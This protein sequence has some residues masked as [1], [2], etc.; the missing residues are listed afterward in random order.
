MSTSAAAVKRYA[1]A[2]FLA[3][4]DKGSVGKVEKELKLVAD[5]LLATPALRSLL[6]H[7]S[8]DVTA[9]HKMMIE[10]FGKHVSELVLNMLLLLCDRRRSDIMVDLSAAYTQIA[11]REL[12]QAEATVIAAKPLSAQE[13]TNVQ[14]SFSKIIGKEIRLEQKIDAELLGGIRVRIGDTLY[15]GSVAGKL[16]R[17]GKELQQTQAL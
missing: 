2:L 14:T 6:A 4:K 3:A 17:I 10:V 16:A 8:V 15:D 11:G 9:K 12:G 7:P 13:L 5:A 1:N